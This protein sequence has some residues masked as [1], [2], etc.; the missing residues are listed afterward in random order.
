MRFRLRKR[1]AFQMNAIIPRE[2]VK[3][4]YY[5]RQVHKR[6][7]RISSLISW[8]SSCDTLDIAKLHLIRLLNKD[9]Y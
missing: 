1:T 2:I 7:S 4:H 5:N 8:T 3:F 6:Q 9:K